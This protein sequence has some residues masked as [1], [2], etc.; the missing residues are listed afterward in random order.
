MK[1]SQIKNVYRKTSTGEWVVMGP[2]NVIYPGACVLVTKKDGTEKS[3]TIERIGKPFMLDG[4]EMVY[5]YPSKQKNEAGGRMRDYKDDGGPRGS[6]AC[7][8]CGSR[9]CE[10]ARGG[11][12]DDD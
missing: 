4:L 11:L 7:Y 3:E 12:C 8:M 10:G 5:G 2:K 6:K 9:Y 1:K